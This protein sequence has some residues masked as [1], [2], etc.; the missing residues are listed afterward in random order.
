MNIFIINGG[1]D[2]QNLFLNRGH[3]IVS[4]MN[5]AD[6]VVFTG[7]E[8]VSPHLYDEEK[9]PQSY[10]SL[11][12]DSIESK[13]FNVAL[14][15]EKPMVGICRGGQFLNV[16]SGGKMYQHVTNHCRSHLLV[17]GELGT[18]VYVS[19]THHQMMRPSGDAIVV[20]TADEGGYKEHMENGIINRVTD[21][22]DVEVVFYPKTRCLCFQPHP[23]FDN[24][25]YEDMR[26][27]F[28]ML[29]N[30]YLLEDF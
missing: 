20:A 3:A 18:S 17:D 13:L 25:I 24:P 4:D 27:Y 19:S 1:R 23:E 30:R 29:I 9:H 28:F 26:A 7:G 8:D 16:M 12:R 6:L 15:L 10:C 5:Q 21:E 22:D 14:K 11:E 2:Y